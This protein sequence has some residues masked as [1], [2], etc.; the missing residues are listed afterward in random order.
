M[1]VIFLQ[2]RQFVSDFAVIIAI[3]CMTYLDYVLGIHTPKLE[4]PEDFK[5][6]L[7]TRG[8]V[9][10]PFHDS[11]YLKENRKIHS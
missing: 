8:W 11:K 5:P 9:I 3:L 2:V 10:S 7:S 1:S 6:T 4:V